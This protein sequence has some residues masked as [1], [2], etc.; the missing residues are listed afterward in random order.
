VSLYY[1][2]T[3]AVIK[4][5]AEETHSRAFAVFYDGHADAE[6]V[7]SALLRI[8]VA[9]ACFAVIG[10]VPAASAAVLPFLLVYGI[11]YFFAEFGPNTTTF[12]LAAELFPVSM[13]A[14]AHGMSSGV[15]KLGAFAEVFLFPLLAQSLKLRG[16]LLLTA[17]LSLLGVAMTPGPPRAG[18]PEPGGCIGGDSGE[19]VA[20]AET[21]LAAADVRR[22][23]TDA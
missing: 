4:L 16:T 13:R 9:R 8:E 22:A 20:A 12:V 14:T 6:W 7:S 15:A 3:S 18:R 19:V 10:F 11:S 21:L 2:G 23:G 5:L 17:A 1:A